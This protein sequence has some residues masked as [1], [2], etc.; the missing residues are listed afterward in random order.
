MVCQALK[1]SLSPGEIGVIDTCHPAQPWR[2]PG[3]TGILSSFLDLPAWSQQTGD[4][5]KD[6]FPPDGRRIMSQSVS[7]WVYP[8][9]LWGSSYPGLTTPSEALYSSLSPSDSTPWSSSRPRPQNHLTW[10]P[11]FLINSPMPLPSAPPPYNREGLGAQYAT[12][13]YPVNV[14]PCSNQPV[15]WYP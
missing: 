15:A 9:K 13:L 3:G 8:H 6:S 14:N 11:D 7:G 5:C 10:T 2:D 12:S 1:D 4:P